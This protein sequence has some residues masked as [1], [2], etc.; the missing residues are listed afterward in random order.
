VV[1]KEYAAARVRK[2]AQEVQE[3][4]TDPA[5]QG[6]QVGWAPSPLGLYSQPVQRIAVRCRRKNGQY[7]LGL[8]VSDLSFEQVLLRTGQDPA[9]ADDLQVVLLAYVYLY[10]Q[11][12]GGIETQ[13]KGGKQGLGVSKRNKK[14]F[15]AQQMLLQLEALAHNT[16]IWARDW[17]APQC[18]RIAS[19]GIQRLVRDVFTTSGH[20]LLNPSD[21]VVHLVLNVRDSLARDLQAS[22][23]ALLKGHV[24]VSLGEI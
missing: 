10:D 13:I 22:L 6:R 18:S 11:R 5:E 8:I 1:A 14:R 19:Y 9:L 17:L 21:Q 7:A 3:W 16:L 15:E 4:I 12:G 20:L 2:V 24:L 23:E